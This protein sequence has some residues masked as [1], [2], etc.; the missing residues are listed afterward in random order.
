[1]MAVLI[2]TGNILVFL[3]LFGEKQKRNEIYFVS[4]LSKIVSLQNYILFT[5]KANIFVK[6][7]KYF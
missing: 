3:W 1:M 2:F 4:I 6:K 7:F 5:K